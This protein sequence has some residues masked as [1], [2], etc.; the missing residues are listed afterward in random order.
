MREGSVDTLLMNISDIYVI[1]LKITCNEVH[2]HIFISSEKQDNLS[3]ISNCM[4]NC[5]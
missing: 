2:F 5:S 3:G 1:N 4:K